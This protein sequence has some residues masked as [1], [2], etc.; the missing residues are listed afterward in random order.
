M[1]VEPFN[2]DPLEQRLDDA[3][4]E[5][6]RLQEMVAQIP[7]LMEQRFRLEL[8]QVHALNQSLVVEQQ[9]FLA[10]L[11][12]PASGPFSLSW[13]VLLVLKRALAWLGVSFAVVGVGALSLTRIRHAAAPSQM[14]V[15][16]PALAT[17]DVVRRLLVVGNYQSLLELKSSEPSW[18]EVS[19]RHGQLLLK[20]TV[21]GEDHR[22]IRLR[23]GLMLFAA[24]PDVMR[25]RVDQGPWQTWPG[26]G[27]AA[28]AFELAPSRP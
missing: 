6:L 1:P 16:P 23:D 28:R 20:D 7:E 8:Q 25:Y 12:C 9:K 3:Q 19:D 24:R 15:K 13:S 17:A 21:V 14:H 27:L 11:A 26:Q 22:R 5:L 4:Q 2:V 10:L 18:V